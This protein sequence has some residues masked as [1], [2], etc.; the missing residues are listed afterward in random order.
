MYYARTEGWLR[1]E[2]RYFSDVYIY[3]DFGLN[4]WHHLKI[5]RRST[6]LPDNKCSTRVHVN[7]KQVKE[8]INDCGSLVSYHAYTE[9]EVYASCADSCNSV[10]GTIDSIR[11]VWL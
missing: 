9:M 7:F 10:S 4:Q 11:F 2:S 8:V 6:G 3:D 5:E 1:F